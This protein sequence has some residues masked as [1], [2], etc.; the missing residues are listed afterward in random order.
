MGG[1][2][3]HIVGA[4][5]SMYWRKRFYMTMDSPTGRGNCISYTLRLAL[6]LAVASRVVSSACLSALVDRQGEQHFE[7]RLKWR[8][9]EGW[10]GRDDHCAANLYSSSWNHLILVG[11]SRAWPL[12]PSFV[13]GFKT[14]IELGARGAGITVGNKTVSLLSSHRKSLTTGNAGNFKN[15]VRAWDMS[16]SLSCLWLTGESADA[17]GISGESSQVARQIEKPQQENKTFSLQ[18]SLWT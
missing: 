9:K 2:L 1:F 14:F 10:H 6:L 18:T 11:R 13:P 17:P 3:E 7:R 15:C 5:L 4:R 16:L 8:T 12:D